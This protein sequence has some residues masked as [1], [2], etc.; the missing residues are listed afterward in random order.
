MALPSHVA[1]GTKSETLRGAMSHHEPNSSPATA[2]RRTQGQKDVKWRHSLYTGTAPLA[3]S[4]ARASFSLLVVLLSWSSLLG[5]VSA[6]NI[7]VDRPAPVVPVQDT[8]TWKRSPLL[9]DNRP[10]PIIPIFMPPLHTDPD[11]S[12]T[13]S[14]PPSKRAIQTDPSAAANGFTIPKAFDTGLSN[15]FTNPCSGF[16]NRM[17]QNQDFNNCNPFS[18]LLQVR[19]EKTLRGGADPY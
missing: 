8:L 12:P 10:P 1:A 18:L 13:L 4:G 14:P 16:L 6:A 19:V 15:N 11:A 7:H 9:I 17:R 5:V 3:S 2:I